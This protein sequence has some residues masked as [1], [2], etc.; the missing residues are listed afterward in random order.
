METTVKKID[1]TK[2]EIDIEVSGEVVK[3]K[4][5][6]VFKRVAKEAKVPGFRP[7]NAPRDVI[8]K[9]YSSTVHE[10][11]L[12]E[13]LPDIYNEALKKESLDVID[14]PQISDVKLDRVKL[15]FKATVEV[16]PDIA[17]KNY[18]GVKIEYKPV[19]VTAEEVK[20]SIDSIKEAAKADVVDD[21]LAKA[22][23]YPNLAELE[24]FLEKQ[25][26][27][28]KESQQRQKIE[29]DLIESLTNGLDFKLPE[30]MVSRQLEDI[31]KRTKVDLAMKGYPRD[32]IE[33]QEKEFAK[34]LEPQA[35]N[36]VKVYLVLLEI[37]KKEKITVDDNMPQKVL[38]F[39]LQEADWKVSD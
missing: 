26:F 18:K 34:T 6:D 25:I 16:S 37:A 21:K 12:K 29:H 23:S 11:V 2:R 3:N 36:Q 35:R 38:E 13:L 20:R 28:Q 31:V 4:F 33:E 7:G 14:M 10:Q 8:E 5:E 27:V 39:L 24:K 19:T 17:I 9:H 30:A 15:S 32:K 1:S 22:L